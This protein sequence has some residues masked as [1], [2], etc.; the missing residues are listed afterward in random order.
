MPL[1]SPVVTR[2]RTKNESL[3]GVIHTAAQGKEEEDSHRVSQSSCVDREGDVVGLLDVSLAAIEHGRINSDT[4]EIG[5]SGS[6]EEYRSFLHN[7]RHCL[8]HLPSWLN[9][10]LCSTQRRKRPILDHCYYTVRNHP[11][12]RIT[13]RCLRLVLPSV[14]FLGLFLSSVL[15]YTRWKR[16]LQHKISQFFQ[17]RYHSLAEQSVHSDPTLQ[18]PG[19]RIRFAFT[20]T[21]MEG[22]VCLPT[23]AILHGPSDYGGLVISIPDSHPHREFRREI[24]SNE[25]TLWERYKA[26]TSQPD[27]SIP[28]SYWHANDLQGQKW[29]CRRPSWS[30]Q[31]FPTCND[32]HLF[33]LSR[34]YLDKPNSQALKHQGAKETSESCPMSS[35]S[36]DTN[37][38]DNYLISQGYYRDVWVHYKPQPAYLEPDGKVLKAILKT[39]RIRFDFDYRN[40]QDVQREALIMER[41]TQ[42]PTDEASRIV[43]P[44]GH[45]GASIL[46]EAVPY[47]VENYVIPGN[48]YE[49]DGASIQSSRNEF[50]P[51]EK[52]RMALDMA[53]SIADLHGHKDGVIVHND[54]Q[55]SQW[56]RT[57][58]GSIK[59]GDFNTAEILEW[60][61]KDESYCKY[62]SG[63]VFGNVSVNLGNLLG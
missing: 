53:E 38:F 45:C 49:K 63:T 50:S 37:D 54:I 13:W 23:S 41:L 7:V 60:N 47:E 27:S 62:N 6:K 29:P 40:L 30:D 42:T 22:A 33:D 46:V 52:L 25:Y 39:T 34:D 43:R 51:S 20:N 5:K 18:H 31:H 8:S 26:N 21:V 28:F 55:L 16:Q 56:L 24:A 58:E 17:R 2:R 9:T 32:F 10:N 59:L 15:G 57:R 44:Y 36:L 19:P 12:L 4:H 3:V 14:L 1:I 11:V 48:G 61:E 35:N